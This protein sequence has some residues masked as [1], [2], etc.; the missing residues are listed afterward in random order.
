MQVI[1]LEELVFPFWKTTRSHLS[2]SRPPEHER[3][4]QSQLPTEHLD[5]AAVSTKV[6]LVDQH[7]LD[8]VHEAVDASYLTSFNHASDATAAWPV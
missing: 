8:H 4:H 7:I 5:E 1:S 2:D 6:R 3:E